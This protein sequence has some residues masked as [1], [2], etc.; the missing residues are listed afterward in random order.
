MLRFLRRLGLTL[1]V[2][3]LALLVAFVSVRTVNTVRTRITADTGVQESTYVSLGG[4]DQ[5]VT[6]RG[7]DVANPVVVYLHGGPGDSSHYLQYPV[8]G[9]LEDTHTWI[10]WDQRGTGRT[11][12]A[13][14]E[15]SPADLSVDRMLADLDEL[16]DY[17]RERFGQ[18]KVVIVGHSWGTVLGTL[19]LQEHPEKVT[20]YVGVG[21]FVDT[22]E[23]AHLAT[24]TAIERARAA[25]DNEDAAA[26]AANL[27]ELDE[28]AAAGGYGVAGWTTEFE[29][30]ALSS[31]Y[32]ACEGE[33]GLA[34]GIATGLASPTI[35]LQDVRWFLSNDSIET[36]YGRQQPLLDTLASYDLR[37]AG[38]EFQVPVSY[39]GGSCD[40]VTPT[41]LA[42]AYAA[43]L[44]APSVD[45]HLIEDAGHVPSVDQPE[46]YVATLETA[47]AD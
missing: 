11:Y 27:A 31:A 37:Q 14:P 20:E 26:M 47:L 40:W 19:Y 32:L 43:S 35:N 9:E 12:Y 42:Q 38:L 5:F 28:A 41:P 21:Q 46:A 18:E 29:N 17:A 6:I 44:T 13:N 2:A 16:V 8:Q 23:G 36:V 1:L 34:H 24:T 25:G 39:V 22:S 45:F 7:E 10:R 15:L 30:R 33:K 3:V 4:I